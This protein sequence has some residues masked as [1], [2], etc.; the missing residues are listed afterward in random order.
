M[1]VWLAAGHDHSKSSSLTS[2]K[3]TLEIM[4]IK[5]KQK[6]AR[7]GGKGKN[8]EG[9]TLGGERWKEQS[10]PLSACVWSLNRL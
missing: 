10:M 9:H 7:L 4:Q 8:I 3:N 1:V 2:H 5:M 6:Q